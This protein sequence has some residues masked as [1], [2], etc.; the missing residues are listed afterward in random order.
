M[1]KANLIE[2]IYQK[3]G[4]MK[5]ESYA[6]FETVFNIMK[7]TLESGEDIRIS[8]FGNFTLRKKFSRLG[9][10][11]QTGERIEI[12]PRRILKFEPSQVLK[13]KINSGRK[14]DLAL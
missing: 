8:S 1:T 13:N 5:K 3:V 4:L 6:V 9:R 14:G 7:E 11:P 12:T 2:E 10:N